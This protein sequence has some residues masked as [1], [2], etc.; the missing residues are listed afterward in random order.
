L[1]PSFRP[2]RADEDSIGSD[3]LAE[4]VDGQRIIPIH[5]SVNYRR[6]VFV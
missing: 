4:E 3:V 1:Y 6:V 5:H 2:G